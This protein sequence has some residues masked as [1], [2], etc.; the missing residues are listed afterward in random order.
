[1]GFKLQKQYYSY[2]QVILKYNTYEQQCK[3]LNHYYRTAPG[4]LARDLIDEGGDRNIKLIVKKRVPLDDNEL[5][6]YNI[7]HDEEKMEASKMYFFYLNFK[8]NCIF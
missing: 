3:F 6:E 1:M 4:T 7:K 5:E 8:T 2:R